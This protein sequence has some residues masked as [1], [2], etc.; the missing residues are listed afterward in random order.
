MFLGMGVG[1][2][3]A[4]IFHL[5]THAF[6]KACLFLGSGSVIHAMGGEQDMRKMGGL[7]KHLPATSTTFIVSTLAIAG[8]PPLSG[9]FSKDEIFWQALSSPHGSK[10]LHFGGLVVAAFTAFYMFRQVFMVFFGEFRGDDHTKHHLHESPPSMTIPLWILMAGA[11]VA[12]VLWIPNVYTPFEHWLEPVMG[13]HPDVAAPLAAAHEAHADMGLE[14]AMIALSVVIAGLG[15]ALAYLMYYR[16]VIDPERISN[17]A[18]GAIY[19]TVLNKYYVDELYEL[20]FVRGFAI[21]GARILAWFDAN[22]IDGVVNGAATLGRGV[23]WFIGLFDNG[24][25]DGA[26]NGVADGA[27]V[28]GRSLRRLQSG[29]IT[30]Y[31]YVIAV[32]VLGGV[33]LY[34]SIAVAS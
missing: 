14:L 21:G 23:G 28:A 15:I 22:V 16:R 25:V 19:R 5:M 10:L 29:A 1:A 7:R 20:V 31:L 8:V 24:V 13:M 18:G 32:G 26:V 9:F 27:W 4:G 17:L 34:W 33:F 3:A 30:A 6:F 12:G 11:V 2:Y